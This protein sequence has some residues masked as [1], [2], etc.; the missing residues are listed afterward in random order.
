[1]VFWK[2]TTH[3]GQLSTRSEEGLRDGEANKAR[4]S[5][6]SGPAKEC[7]LHPLADGEDFNQE[8]ELARSSDDV[9]TRGEELVP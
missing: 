3:S 7:E 9:A 6:S 8:S 1:M 5:R 2:N 4:M